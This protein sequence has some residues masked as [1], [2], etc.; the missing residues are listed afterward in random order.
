MRL[1]FAL[2]LV[3]QA[4]FAAPTDDLAKSP[5]A[6]RVTEFIRVFNG[7]DEAT[8]RQWIETNYADSV[9]A[10]RSVDARL[11]NFGQLKRD[12]YSV[13]LARVLTVEPGMVS[14][15]LHTARDEWF[16]VDFLHEPNPPYKLYGLKIEHTEPP[17]DSTAIPLT[18]RAALDSTRRLLER[19][20]AADEF[21]GVVLVARHGKPILR[22]AFGYADR[23]AQ[24]RNRVDTK[25]NVGSIDKTFT[26][27]AIERLISAGRLSREDSV[28]RIL[29]EYLNP[30]V[31]AKVTVGQ[32]LEHTSGAPDFFG[33]EF[34][35]SS[36]DSIRTLRDYLPFFAAKSLNF[37]PGSRE[38]Y[39]NGGFLVLGLI[40]EKLTGQSYY[41]HIRKTIFQPLRMKNSDW[42][43]VDEKVRNRALGYTHRWSNEEQDSPE[44][45][46]NRSLLPARGSS[47]GG[48]YSTAEDLLKFVNA[49][50][51]GK[52]QSGE[53]R[54]GLGIA[55]G[56]PGLNAALESSH[57]KLP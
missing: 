39:S 29:P 36:K 25:F 56:A 53:F 26:R 23:D 15:L 6:R 19:A 10:V 34:M 52:I 4:A 8:L 24:I 9:L 11:E 30:A 27:L 42:F 5:I 49:L 41:D 17:N 21:S 12:M 35:R 43:A 3:L 28:G 2:L 51:Q 37:E 50:E 46:S 44:L 55:G 48:G 16:Q 18:E 7:G 32:L 54:G 22:Q 38:Q 57:A 47:A 20:A 31:R 1:I 13:Q 45:R 33:E 40:L 14:T